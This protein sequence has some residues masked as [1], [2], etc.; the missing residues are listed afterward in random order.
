M[1]ETFAG[2]R[3]KRENEWNSAVFPF[4]MT[5][6]FGRQ[7][8]SKG[9]YL[10]RNLLRS[11][12]TTNTCGQISSSIWCCEVLHQDKRYNFQKELH[13]CNEDQ[14]KSLGTSCPFGS[15]IGKCVCPLHS[16]QCRKLC[17]KSTVEAIRLSSQ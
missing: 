6:S 17:P 2:D 1:C 9:T 16:N 8:F 10:M 12:G 14:P 3:E 11:S 13:C 7:G 5:S 15:P 4:F